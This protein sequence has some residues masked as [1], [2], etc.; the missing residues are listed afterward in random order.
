MALPHWLP[1]WLPHRKTTRPASYMST[2]RG[3]LHCSTLEAIFATVHVAL[4][5]GIFLTNYLIDM[6]ASNFMCGVVEALPFL[7]QVLFLF[8]PVL[9]RRLNRR[10]PVVVVFALAHRMAWLVLI[11]IMF[12]DW[13]PAVRHV[14]IIIVLFLGNGCAVIAGNAWLGWMADLVPASIRGAY[15]GRRNV[16]LGVTSLMALLIGSWVLT[17]AGHWGDRRIGYA[18]CF[19]T[20]VVSALFSAWILTRQHEPPLT[21]LVRWTWARLW[22]ESLKNER[23]KR[24]LSFMTV[25]QF[26]LGLSAAFFGVHMVRVLKMTPA[27]MGLQALIGSTMALTATRIWARPLDRLG[28]KAVLVSSGILVALHVWIWFAAKPGFLWPVWLTVI[29]GGF[30]WSGFNL[31]TFNWPQVMTRPSQRQYALG[32]LGSVSGLT[33]VFASLIGGTLTTVLPTTLFRV[34]QF[35]FLHYHLLFALSALGRL[36]AIL[37]LAP[38]IPADAGRLEAGSSGLLISTLRCMLSKP[39]APNN[40]GPNL[41]GNNDGANNLVEAQKRQ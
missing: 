35:E 12:F 30:A 8:S 28:S 21:P 19:G 40:N 26:S 36:S 6:G 37:F 13:S 25:W 24:Y 32:L 31:A 3:A 5:Q 14:L 9:V 7:T 23:F 38:R 39:S 17:A 4:T 29:A 16:Y 11:A 27:Q 10:K 15:Y 2:L 20:A 33:F 34:G 18:I 1:H 22:V 41:P